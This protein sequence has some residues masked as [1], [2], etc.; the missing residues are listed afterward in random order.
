LAIEVQ[1]LTSLFWENVLDR[2]VNAEEWDAVL[3]SVEEWDAV[4]QVVN[5]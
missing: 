5:G 4:L 2:M 1:V 3:V